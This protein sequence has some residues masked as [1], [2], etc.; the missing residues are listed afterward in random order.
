MNGRHGKLGRVGTRCSSSFPLFFRGKRRR[1]K[2]KKEE[3]E[4]RRRKKK[5][6]EEEERE[7]RK[8]RKSTG[9]VIA[10][11]SLRQEVMLASTCLF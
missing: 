4:R 11:F 10:T 2:K 5:K 6:K 1:K 9:P 3:E 7:K 8:E